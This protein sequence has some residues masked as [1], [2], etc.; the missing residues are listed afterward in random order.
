MDAARAEADALWAAKKVAYDAE[1][2]AC[3]ARWDAHVVSETASLDA[4]TAEERQRCDDARAEQRALF[5][6]YVDSAWV[7][8]DLWAASEREAMAEFLADA[9]D[10]WRWILKSYCLLKT[11][12]D[13]DDDDQYGNSCRY[14]VDIGG[15]KKGIEIEVHDP[16]LSYGQPD[17]D[18]LDIK[19]I[20]D[21]ARRIDYAVA[22][23][24]QGVAETAAA[25]AALVAAEQARIHAYV[26]VERQALELALT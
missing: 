13:H 20:K 7:R 1:I 25:E 2:E 14:N 10:A 6:I 3:E 16:L 22:F 21:V 26:E 4:N 9:L 23:T 17:G 5:E 18:D 19:H 12:D 11:D 24:M 15:Y 8:F